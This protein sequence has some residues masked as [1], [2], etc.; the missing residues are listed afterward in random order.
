VT[1]NV[2]PAACAAMQEACL[3]GDYKTALEWQDRLYPLHRAMFRESSPAPAKFG[4]SLL[5]RCTEEVRAPIGTISDE[6]KTE[7]RA[8]MVHAG[9]LN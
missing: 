4:L 8:A 9:L 3:A 5:G 1:A 6:T 7:I 2:A